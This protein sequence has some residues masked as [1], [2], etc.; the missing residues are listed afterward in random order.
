MYGTLKNRKIDVYCGWHRN[1]IVNQHPII[2]KDFVLQI[3]CL[4]CNGAGIFD[5]GIRKEHG[6]C[7]SC[8]GTGKQYIGTI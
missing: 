4:E 6:R 5:C 2:E 8:K 3:K 1:T 7:I